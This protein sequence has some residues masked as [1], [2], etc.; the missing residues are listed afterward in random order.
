MAP[1]LF[2]TLEYLK[3]ILGHHALNSI[4]EPGLGR[5]GK[6]AGLDL[7]VGDGLL[8]V[9]GDHLLQEPVNTVIRL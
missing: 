3:S 6:D 8:V 7:V 4:L 2:G 5:V 9:A 1:R